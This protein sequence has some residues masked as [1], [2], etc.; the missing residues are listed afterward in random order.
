MFVHMKG[1]VPAGK[2]CTEI[3]RSW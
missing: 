3:T 2:I 1:K